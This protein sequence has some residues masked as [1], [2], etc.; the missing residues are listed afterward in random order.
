MKILIRFPDL[1]RSDKKFNFLQ[2]KLDWT[3][4]D[5]EQIMFEWI[6]NG[7]LFLE[8]QKSH[9]TLPNPGSKRGFKVAPNCKYTR[10]NAILSC[11]DSRPDASICPRKKEFS[12]MLPSAGAEFEV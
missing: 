3:R 9:L 8:L 2:I 12:A 6:S 10:P 7:F 1:L 4:P 5:Q 11:R